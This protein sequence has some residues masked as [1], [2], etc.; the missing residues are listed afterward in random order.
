MLEVEIDGVRTRVP[1]CTCGKCIDR[2]KR[3]DEDQSIPYNKDL[4]SVYTT[5]YPPKKP[6]KDNGYV[7][8]AKLSGFD[9]QFK[10][11]LPDGLKSTMKGDYVP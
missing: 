1:Q 2:K 9:N 5:D 6:I 11:T 3:L 4:A 8:R 10:E 7:N